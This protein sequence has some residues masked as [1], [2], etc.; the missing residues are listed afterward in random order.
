MKATREF[1]E[2][3]V[4][5]LF[6]TFDVE[7]SG[8]ALYWTE[9]LMGYSEEAIKSAW[10]NIVFE[11]KPRFMPELKRIAKILD[12]TRYMTE[13]PKQIIELKKSEQD[14]F[15]EVLRSCREGMRDIKQGKITESEYYEQSAK[16]YEGWQMYDAA[17]ELRRQI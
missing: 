2:R 15:R 10:K 9:F 13:K 16:M 5:D 7:N 1:A 6:L 14:Q 11:C 4:K 3:Y 17:D 12:E 8:L